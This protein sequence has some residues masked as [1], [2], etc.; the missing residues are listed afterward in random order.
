MM[1]KAETK[2]A[3]FL[4]QTNL[5]GSLL[6]FAV[7]TELEIKLFSSSQSRNCELLV[8]GLLHTVKNY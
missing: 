7:S 2:T 1:G 6:D 4:H 8:S 3:V 5:P